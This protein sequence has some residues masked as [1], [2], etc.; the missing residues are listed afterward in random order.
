M[1]E[2][3]IAVCTAV[4]WIVTGAQTVCAQPY[5]AAASKPAATARA[6]GRAS[7][8]CGTSNCAGNRAGSRGHDV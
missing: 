4:L 7:A 2:R 1:T 5:G 3:I 8:R 6:S